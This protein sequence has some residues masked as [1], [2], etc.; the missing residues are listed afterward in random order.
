MPRIVP[1]QKREVSDCRHNSN[2]TR[3]G[4]VPASFFFFLAETEGRATEAHMDTEPTKKVLKISAYMVK[5]TDIY[6]LH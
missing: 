2:R 6:L 1:R 3:P 5:K 4:L